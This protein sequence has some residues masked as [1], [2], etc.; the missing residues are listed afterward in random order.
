MRLVLLLLGLA[1][2]VRADDPPLLLCNGQ[3][4][5][6]TA[7]ARY[8]QTYFADPGGDTSECVLDGVR[9]FSLDGQCNADR[10]P[11]LSRRK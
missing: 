8:V 9:Y 1:L 6:S 4:P 2:F 3:A 11:Q 7:Y 10:N 5:L